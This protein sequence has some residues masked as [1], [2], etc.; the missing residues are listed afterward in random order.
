MDTIAYEAHGNLYLNITNRC[1]ANCV[2]CIKNYSDGVYGYNLK[3]KKEPGVGEVI[4]ELEGRELSDYREVVFTGLGEPTVRFDEM[5]EITRWL[6]SRG[7][8]VRLDT[9]GHVK[10]LYPGSTPAK[11]LSAAGMDVVSVSLNAHDETTYNQLCRPKFRGSYDS[12]L[13]FAGDVVKEGMKLRLT[14][15][16]LPA[17]DIGKCR[18]LARGLRGE[19]KVRSYATANP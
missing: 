17:V 9:I 19:F 11:E 6:K 13:G 18:E 12:M 8:A 3:L 14:V 2:F 16:D 5:L 1:S 7:S 10:L 15:V 4:G